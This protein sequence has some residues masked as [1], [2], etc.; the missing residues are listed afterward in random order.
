MP[1]V[2]LLLVGLM[3]GE[4]GYR[5]AWGWR[6]SDVQRVVAGVGGVERQRV[7]EMRRRDSAAACK[8][9]LLCSL[10]LRAASALRPG[11]GA[12]RRTSRSSSGWPAI[13]STASCFSAG[14][15]RSSTAS[16]R[17][18]ASPSDHVIYLAEKPE[19]DAKRIT[20][21]ST[22]EEIVKAFASSAQA[23]PGRCRLR[24]P[25][26]P[27]HVRRQGR[28]VQPAGAGHDAGGLR[29]AAEEAE[30]EARRV[31]RTPRARAARSSR[32]WPA[33]GRTI[34]TATRT[35]AERFAT[36]FGGYFVDALAGERG[37]RGQE[38]PDVGA[39]GV[40]RSRSGRSASRT[41][42]KG[43]MLT[44][45]AILDDN[46]DKKGTQTPAADGKQ[47]RVA[48]ILTLGLGRRPRRCPPIRSCARSM[49]SGATRAADRR[50]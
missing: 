45:H 7:D 33:P 47:G 17:R 40:R 1:I 22:K 43:I 13:R 30:V 8:Q 11:S 36:L 37:R 50:R 10:L 31:R 25:D 46:G 32:R 16:T 23:G 27:R 41:S 35:G 38:R 26:R 12:D 44:E 20:G 18:W 48:S 19:A 21:K 28:E 2:L 5:R 15:R 9:R 14:R 34:V 29:A 4:W 24:G 39:R 3:C 49:P 42:G 6:E